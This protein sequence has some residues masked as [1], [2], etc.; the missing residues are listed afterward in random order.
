MPIVIYQ[1]HLALDYLLA[2]E[3]GVCGNFNQSDL[4][5]P[6][7]WWWTSSNGHCHHF[8]KGSPC[9]ITDL[10][11]M[12]SK[13]PLWWVVSFLGEFKILVRA[14]ILMLG[15]C[16]LLLCLLPFISHS[17][18]SFIETL[19]WKENCFSCGSYVEI[20]ACNQPRLWE[21][22]SLILTDLS[23]KRENVVEQNGKINFNSFADRR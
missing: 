19:S 17:A 7:R 15:R 11:R 20:S 5:L 14:V 1:N 2:E 6:D 3:G 22:C 8:Q 23:I 9:P 13:W 16:L 12:E 18:S 10:E 21:W 4:L